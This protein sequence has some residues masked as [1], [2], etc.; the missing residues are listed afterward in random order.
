MNVAGTQD[1]VWMRRAIDLARGG[2]GQTH[3]N[4]MVGAVVVADG[5]VVGEGFHSRFGEA[6]A[7]VE[8][9]RQA[10]DRAR[11][12]TLYVTLEPCTHAG[13]T[14]P[15]CRLIV[16]SG[17]QRVVYGTSDPHP[18][19]GGG[20][21]ELGGEGVEVTGGV[22][23]EQAAQI[24]AAFLWWHRR[25][26]SYVAL[27][28]AVSLDGKIAERE[29]VRTDLTGAE[30][31][32]EV[33]RLRAAH[34]AILVGSGTVRVDDPLLTVRDI[35]SPRVAPLRVVLDSSARM[36]LA[37]RLVTTVTEAPV[38]V[39]V[40]DDAAPA[41]IAALRDSGVEVQEIERNHG[42]GLSLSAALDALKDRRRTAVLCEGGANLAA[43]LLVAGH[44]QRVHWFVAPRM[45]G[46]GGV[47]ALAT[48]VPDSGSWRLTHCRAVGDDAV[49]EWNHTELEAVTR[50]N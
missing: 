28:L 11:G 34:D 16:N 49:I 32:R 2:W 8:A 39:L 19:A 17:I 47:D 29:G 4:P 24:N 37:S 30:A 36:S 5:Q 26:T 35:P 25:K 46:P 14:P 20:A 48:Q 15:C 22:L 38:L 7:E 27:K 42:F 50:E 12:A 23:A 41:R 6:H 3:P 44:V 45:I 9:I 33:M 31:R 13:K 10:G 1:S 43:S 18:E 21:V 40:G